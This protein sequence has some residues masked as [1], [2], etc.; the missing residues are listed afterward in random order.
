MHGRRLGLAILILVFAGLAGAV[1]LAHDAVAGWAIARVAHGMG[2]D[3]REARL[4]LGTRSLSLVDP[5]VTTTRGE[6][7]F[8]ADRVDVA[9]SLRDL[10]PGG[11]RKFG[12]RAVDLQ[13]PRVTLIHEADGSYNVTPPPA[14]AAQRPDKT[15]LDVRVRVRD[16]EIT[17]VDRFVVPGRERRESVV[18]VRADAILAPT[19]P[20]YYRIDGTLVDNGRRYPIA[21]R[22]RFDHARRFASQHWWAP[23]IPIGALADFALSTHTVNVV[24]G[25]LLGLDAR[26]YGFVQPDGSTDTHV[27]V[28]A[29]LDDGT[30]YAQ[31][32][33]LP[34]RNAHGPLLLTSDGFQTTGIDATLAGAPLHLVGGAYLAPHPTLRF[35]LTARGP[36]DRLKTIAAAAAKRPLAGD[37]ALA[38]RIDGALDRPRVEGT[39]SSNRFVYG[40]YVLGGAGGTLVVQGQTLDIVQSHARYGP[41]ALAGAGTLTLGRHVAANLVT[42]V[43]GPSDALPYANQLL[44]GTAVDG[45]IVLDGIDTRLGAQGFLAAR[46]AG[47]SLDAPFAVSPDG[48]GTIGPVALARRDGA[49]AYARLELDRP[50]GAVTGVVSVRRLALL[51]A[52]AAA[53]PGLDPRALPALH[54]ALDGDVALDV[55]GARLASA[56]GALHVRGASFGTLALGDADVRIGAAGE[57]AELQAIRVRGPLADVDGDGAYEN[58]TLALEGRARTS[59]ARL[60]PLLRGI[61]A[62]GAIDAPFRVVADGGEQVLQVDGARLDGVRLRGIPV[63]A[64][65][66]TLARRG[67]ALDVVAAQA[68]VAGGSVVAHGT[69][70]RGDAT[71]IASASGIDAGALGSG[72]LPLA[73]GRID[74]LAAL[75]GSL[76]AP[77]GTLGVTISGAALR[78][79]P[80]DAA[81]L[82]TYDGARLAF[83]DASASFGTAVATLDGAVDGLRP[84]ALAPRLALGAHVRGLDVGAVAHLAKLPLRYPDAAVDGDFRITGAVA[85][86]S[87]AGTARIPA[88]SI[89]GLAFR[90]VVVPVRGSLAAVTVSGGH[91]TVGTT[92]IGFD[93][94]ATPARA[95]VD[96]RAPHVDLADFNDYFD[97]ADTL[98]GRGHA[99]VAVTIGRADFATSGNVALRGAQVRRLPVGDVAATWSSRGR[100]IAAQTV[101]GGAHGVLRAH[102][103]AT[104]PARDPLRRLAASDLDVSATVAGL[105]L[106]TWLP[107]LGMRDVAVLGRVDGSA[108]VRG[109]AP[110][111]SLSADASLT[112]GRVGRVP[113]SSLTVAASAE[114]GRARVTRAELRALNLSADGS[115]TF[116]FGAHDPIAL[117]LHATTPDVGALAL[118]AT[119]KS[120]DLGGAFDGTLR[121]D[122]T[123][124]AP[125]VEAVA[126]LDRPRYG[127]LVA[128]RA[129]LDLAFAGRRLTL[130]DASLDETAGRVA[131]SGSVPATTRPPFIDRRDAPVQAR[132]VAEHLDL[133]DFSA[134]FPKGTKLGG[135]VDGDVRVGGTLAA[136]ALGGTLALAKG[137]YSSP[138]LASPVQ[139]A[140]LAVRLDRRTA[141]FTTLH[142]DMGGGA[143]DGSG[144]ASIGDLRAPQ[145]TLAFEVSARAKNLGLD[146]P[147]MVRAK[148]D[149]AVRVSRAPGAP[150]LVG[151]NL[152]FTHSRLSI[153][154]LLPKR[155]GAAGA[156]AL[157]VSFDL[158]VAA[159]SDDRV[160]GPNIDIG[161]TG[162]AVLGGTLAA[163][164]LRGRFRS[165]DG[166]MSFYRTFVLQNA[167]VAFDPSD[168]IIPYVDATAT[169]HVP[170]PSTDVLLHAYG[171]AT[172]LNLDL[173]SRPEYDRSQIVGLLVNAQALGAVSGVAQTSP[174]T[175][176]GNA[177]QNAA[178]GFA[179]SQLTNAIFQPF[180]SSV[181]NALGFQTFGVSPS[182]TGG[183]TA[184]ATRKLGEH[185]T[186]SFAESQTQ[187]GQR[188]SVGISGNFSDA[189]SV[190]LTLYGGGG[191]ASP[192][193]GVIPPF[194]LTQPKNLELEALVPPEGSNGFVF[195]FV[196]KFWAGK[197]PAPSLK[198]FHSEAA[199]TPSPQTEALR[200]GW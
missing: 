82:A 150:V 83:D 155:G 124:V 44:P 76:A 183:F 114:R 54:G 169:T 199:A 26:V 101:V 23:E 41:L 61:A 141:T 109:V 196:K 79:T 42:T 71:L 86:P 45:V 91:A 7:V 9:Y 37:V 146:V 145:R 128:Q 64:A 19:D 74:A 127:K 17:F 122:G 192:V 92:T 84:N 3:V 102:G 185:L 184:S 66:A 99:V 111:L 78:G 159:P 55:S 168:G 103:S 197:P 156:P 88:G 49:A 179:G 34:V 136:P 60:R 134:V 139:N 96:V 53:L 6:P 5:V 57:R 130:R 142:A 1:A 118:G 149:G 153:M 133:G 56:A 12:L 177:L 170:D 81:A 165:T 187:T 116:G 39:F 193:L 36:L 72:A 115:G 113:I 140:T 131:A 164:T 21:G 157:P 135:V 87:I 27:G 106:A 35:V 154:A 117:A 10:L 189:T 50:H 186:A 180:S 143:I 62:S 11:R 75:G 195:S 48:A 25:R 80:L 132:V 38:L 194:G 188:Q 31:Q 162:G 14:G 176:N 90:D 93:A 163:P 2:Y 29:R 63:G 138:L 24:S 144:T 174:G 33:A 65:S 125:S 171:F 107:A 120:Y 67:D 40:R 77:H 158:A 105:D 58:G 52:R 100:T 167:T 182:L 70:G 152:A 46:G 160:Q 85:S 148:I 173:A 181:G 147:K 110:A 161:A 97:A 200:S 4:S 129:H 30:V 126:T 191:G 47:G 104:L 151:G 22:A 8:A 108:R 190:Q 59:F 123:R 178:L 121:V 175:T 20:A 51:A 112:Q 13:R 73:G 119:G 16:G 198:T 43:A 94:A 69:L 166:S 98:E 32:L 95:H 18:A 68:R 172:Q 15:P 28:H 89:N 137:S